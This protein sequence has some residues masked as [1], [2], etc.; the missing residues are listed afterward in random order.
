MTEYISKSERKRRFRHEEQ[1]AEELSRLTKKD[2]KLAPISDEVKEEIIT[3]RD[4]K[5]GALKRQIKYLAKVMRTDDVEA[6]L[7]FL[8]ERKGSDLKVNR[9]HHEAE[10]LRDN[11]INQAVEDQKSC[12][13]IGR[14][15]GEDWSASEIDH[16]VARL[17]WLNAGDMRRATFLYVKTKNHMHYKELFKMVK[18]ALEREEMQLNISKD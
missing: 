17:P 18:A 3:C 13:K 6:I 8:E 1:A 16:A 15:W 9:L 14:K 7:T 2:L 11:I 4:L 12:L 5:G 10:H